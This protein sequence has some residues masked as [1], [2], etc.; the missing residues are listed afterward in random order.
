M[1]KGKKPGSVSKAVQRFCWVSNLF[2]PTLLSSYQ[3]STMVLLQSYSP[4]LWPLVQWSGQPPC[5]SQLSTPHSG[6][7]HSA[8]TTCATLQPLTPSSHCPF[9]PPI[10]CALPQLPKPLT[11]SLDPLWQLMLNHLRPSS[12]INPGSEHSYICYYQFLVSLSL[13]S[14]CTSACAS[15]PPPHSTLCWSLS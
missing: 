3:C 1:S 4:S 11:A 2:K 13:G 14:Y 12:V 9:Y 5:S 8:T 15:S 10:T 6:H 7:Q